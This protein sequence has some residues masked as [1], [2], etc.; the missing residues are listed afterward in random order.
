MRDLP[1]AAI[2]W[3]ARHGWK[4]LSA[5]AR[6][7][8]DS[9]LSESAIVFSPHYDDECLGCGGTLIRKK[10]A[11]AALT[12]VHMTDGTGSH[13]DA[14][15]A[16]ELR[17]IRFAEGDAA[18]LALGIPTDDVVHFEFPETRLAKLFDDAVERVLVLLK[19]LRPKSVFVPFRGEPWLWSE[20]HLATT[21][22]VFAA[23]RIY[24]QRVTIYEYPI[25]YWFQWPWV[26][27]SLRRRK[28]ARIILRNS[29]ALRRGAF[30]VKRLNAGVYIGGELSQKWTALNQ[31]ASQMTRLRNG[32]HWP[33]LHDVAHGQFLSCFFQ[34]Y[35]FF[36][37][38]TSQVHA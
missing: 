19:K 21:R 27:P 23:L 37:E 26:R 31:H 18:A 1:P 7:L 24:D 28:E 10:A 29:V 17:R 5:R 35:E 8:T 15:L 32:R 20:D 2:S 33:T 6:L 3:L 13:R 11:G 22:S 4:R 36:A 38:T 25:W 9:D 34:P 12:L 30:G 16:E 14:I